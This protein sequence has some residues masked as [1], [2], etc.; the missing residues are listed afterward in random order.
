M[1]VLVARN[2]RVEAR[3]VL[4]R[5]LCSLHMG[6]RALDKTSI[7]CNPEG[8]HVL[9]LALKCRLKFNM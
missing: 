6:F 3:I 2:S 4:P 5:S 8:F 7:P 1:A 9:L